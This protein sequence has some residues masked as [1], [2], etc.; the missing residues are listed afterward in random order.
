MTD[1]PSFVYRF[2][3][4][5]KADG[6]PLL[7]LHGTGGDENDLLQLG[8][9]ISP[10]SALLSPRG[11]VLEHGMPRFFRRLAEG[12]FDEQD[13][14]KR[15]LELGAFVEDARRRH[16]IAAPVAVGFSNGANI[17]AAL[18]L[19][20][21]DVLAGAVLLRAMV[22][23][24]DPPKA[25]LD[26][27]PVLILSGQADPIVPAS[28]AARLSAMLADAGAK[29]TLRTLPAGHQLTQADVSLARDWITSVDA[30]VA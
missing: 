2:E 5:S 18:L 1:A 22:P 20:K 26:G 3:K 13:V 4:A 7:L 9:M 15:A 24:S 10:G 8:A 21:P 19:M 27:K 30:R 11:R 14:R 12:V 17:A 29:V 25:R 6:P 23:L 28:N 16:G